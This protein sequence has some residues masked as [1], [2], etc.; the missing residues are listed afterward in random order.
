[1][2]HNEP[3]LMVTFSLLSIKFCI[4]I[5]N[6]ANYSLRLLSNRI[7]AFLLF[8]AGAVWCSQHIKA[9]ARYL[10]STCLAQFSLWQIFIFKCVKVKTLKRNPIINKALKKG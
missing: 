10:S 7:F 3:S 5:Y 4:P 2:T 6:L 9:G 1:M 8:L